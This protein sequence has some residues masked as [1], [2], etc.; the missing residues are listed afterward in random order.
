MANEMVC[1]RCQGR[2]CTRNGSSRGHRRFECQDCGRTFAATVGTP[3]LHL[4]TP[5]R[6]IIRAIMVV[7]RRGSLWAAEE[8][9]G[10]NYETIAV[11]MRRLGDHADAVSQVL[12]HD[13]ELSQVEIDEIWSFVGRKRG[14]AGPTGP[15]DSRPTAD[16]GERWGCVSQDRASRFVIAWA[17]GPREETLAQTV[18][19]TRQR[20]K[21]QVGIPY[22][23]DG[24]APYAG[25]IKETYRDA[26]PSRVNPNWKILKPTEEI[27]LTQAI[28]HRK[29]RRLQRVEVRAV[30]G[31]EAELPCAVH[32][33][34]L[35]G[36]LRDRL[37]C[38][39]RKT[40][41]FAKAVA[42]WDA[43]LSLALVEQNWLRPHR[44]LRVPLPE[45]RDGRRYHQ[46]T[47]A[48]VLNLTDHVWSWEEFLRLP[49]NQP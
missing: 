13:L 45:P 32:L 8:L 30:F 9:T 23:S 12:V 31:V 2:H 16:Q 27:A 46:R 29:G 25:A 34:R 33:E 20:T 26:E 24:W 19:T 17:S 49:A 41:G 35:N 15:A 1:L 44:A 42:T 14:W 11:W 10:H 4:H 5:L 43:L 48:M 28:K 22:V 40:H 37:N 7:L 47:P 36:T 39:T 6:E 3:L 38:L 21:G 18:V